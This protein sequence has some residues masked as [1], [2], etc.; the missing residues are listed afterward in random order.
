MPNKLEEVLDRILNRI[1]EGRI[2]AAVWGGVLL[3]VGLVWFVSTFVFLVVLIGEAIPGGG[4]GLA[5]VVMAALSGLFVVLGTGYIFFF[6][7]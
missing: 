6:G 7:R 3:F 5:T 2:L 1:I 4:M